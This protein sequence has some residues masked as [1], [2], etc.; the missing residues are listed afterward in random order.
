MGQARRGIQRLEQRRTVELLVEL[1]EVVEGDACLRQRGHALAPG[2]ISQVTQHAV[3]LAFVR[4][5]AQLLLD[6]F[7]RGGA[8]A[9]VLTRLRVQAQRVGTGEPAHAAGQV[10]VFEQPVTAMAF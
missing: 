5:L 6:A 10:H 4:H 2:V 9:V 3:A 1:A 7:D 8:G